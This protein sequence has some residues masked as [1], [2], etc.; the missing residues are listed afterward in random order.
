MAGVVFQEQS[1]D[2]PTPVKISVIKHGTAKS[3]VLSGQS[4][5]LMQCVAFDKPKLRA[6]PT[7]REKV[8]EKL[9]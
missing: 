5:Y 2:R 3:L 1:P 7:R 4:E 8:L 6:V 9:N